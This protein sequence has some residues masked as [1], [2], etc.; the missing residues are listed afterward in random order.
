[1]SDPTP[2]D[3][4]PAAPRWR[5]VARWIR[6]LPDRLLHG[7]RRRTVVE[8]LRRGPPRR[9]LLVVCHGNIC[10]SPYAAAALA[11]AIPARAGWKVAISSAGF[12]GPGRAP[13][14]EAVTIAA[15]HGV[16]LSGHRS[17]TL[18][19]AL[20]RAADL[21]VVMDEAQRRAVVGHLGA[22]PE[23]VVLLGDFDPAPIVTRTI[24]DPVDRPLDVFDETY[25]RI[26]RCATV[27]AKAI[28]AARP[29]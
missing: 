21:V 27:L 24:R 12:I 9:A 29:G 10:R 28:A 2:A 16:D 3:R 22:R 4:R 11:H 7:W 23:D 20:V 13:P 6:H 19:P 8:R 5:A 14:R 26:D 15:R 17:Q 18:T 25:T 1:M